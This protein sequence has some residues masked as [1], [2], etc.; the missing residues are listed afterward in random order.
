MH[1]LVNIDREKKNVMIIECGG[2]IIRTQ[3]HLNVFYQENITTTAPNE[4]KKRRRREFV[5]KNC[6]TIKLPCN[7]H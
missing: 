4:W 7:T 6:I 3:I 5:N 2:S 1:I